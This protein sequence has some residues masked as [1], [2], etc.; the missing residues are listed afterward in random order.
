M[1]VHAT[2]QTALTAYRLRAE[3]AEARAQELNAENALLKRALAMLTRSLEDAE[4]E[5]TR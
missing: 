4:A 1:N 3:A 5:S 2:L